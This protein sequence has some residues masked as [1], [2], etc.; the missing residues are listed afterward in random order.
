VSLSTYMTTSASLSWL[1]SLIT[2]EEFE[3][4]I[5]VREFVGTSYEWK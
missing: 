4:D 1:N 3:T 2:I 5:T